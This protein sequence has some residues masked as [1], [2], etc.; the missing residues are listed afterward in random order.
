MGEDRHNPPG[1]SDHEPEE[2]LR[3]QRN[4]E[5]LN[6]ATR[7]REAGQLRVRKNVRTDRER[8]PVSKKREEVRIERAPVEGEAREVPDAEIGEDEIVVQVFEE[9]V[10]VSKRVVLKEEIRLRKEVIE[11]EAIVEEDVRR[12]EVEIDDIDPGGRLREQE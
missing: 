9:E 11:E 6:A 5:E 1:G 8:F 10:V 2:D 4:E 3:V 12:E 7:A